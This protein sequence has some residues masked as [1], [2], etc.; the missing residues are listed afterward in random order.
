MTL[1]ISLIFHF[2]IGARDW[3]L[4]LRVCH[5]IPKQILRG[6]ERVIDGFAS[7]LWL[8][9]TDQKA[10]L[11]CLIVMTGFLFVLLFRFAKL[12]LTTFR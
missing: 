7:H 9:F 3:R 8:R 5:Q 1:S 11:G 6:S 4:I 2:V 10:F 12:E